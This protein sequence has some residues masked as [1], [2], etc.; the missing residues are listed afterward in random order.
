[1]DELPQPIPAKIKSAWGKLLT[2]LTTTFRAAGDTPKIVELAK[3]A[4]SV[5]RDYENENI[6][7]RQ[8]KGDLHDLASFVARWTEN[9]WRIALVLHAA[10]EVGKAHL[11]E[12]ETE[13]ATNAIEIMRWFSCQ[14]LDVLSSRRRESQ[15]A[16]LLALSDLR[17]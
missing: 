13:T 11:R 14:Q 12:L 8:R 16:R 9:A 6:R 15:K 3:G 10:K 17:I 1:M 2:D 5:F 7:R 4:M